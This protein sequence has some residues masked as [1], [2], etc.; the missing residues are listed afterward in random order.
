MYALKQVP[1]EYASTDVNGIFSELHSG[2]LFVLHSDKAFGV[3]LDSVRGVW[4]L[5]A[6]DNP[7][8]IGRALRLNARGEWE[9]DAYLR[10]PGSGGISSGAGATGA[11]QGGLP[12]T[13]SMSNVA[14]ERAASAG[15]V[16]DT[17]RRASMTDHTTGAEVASAAPYEAL[18]S[19]EKRFIDTWAAT[20]STD[21]FAE[22]MQ[23]PRA[24]I[25][26]YLQSDEHR[27]T[28][29]ASSS[30]DPPVLSGPGGAGASRYRRFVRAGSRMDTQKRDRIVRML[31]SNLTM[32][33][34][35]IARVCSS[36]VKTVS[37]LAKACGLERH[38][39]TWHPTVRSAVF[40]DF[41]LFPETSTFDL[42]REHNV[43][44]A[45]VCDFR[46]EFARIQR[47]WESVRRA[48][49]AESRR[50]ELQASLDNDARSLAA[51]RP[52]SPQPGTSSAS[53]PLTEAQKSEI[54]RW[55]GEGMLPDSLSIYL[56][57][58]ET[59]VDAYMRTSEY[60]DYV[61]GLPP[62]AASAAE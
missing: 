62:R 30:G 21:N 25:D 9:L 10:A 58:P 41:I 20:L 57:V 6:Q 4:R 61:R 19:R 32:T 55:G 35:A 38:V 1:D 52:P 16:T 29:Q 60:R 15:S 5:V 37:E 42:A 43:S 48:D 31:E 7:S 39:H 11:R 22:L 18:T 12:I 27:S 14:P 28:V 54:R 47:E 13:S 3:A 17:A 33:Y 51:Q 8:L 49:I 34:S 53:L 26:A 24:K 50:R 36:T 40:D 23:G 59:V 44:P 45:M 56:N 46:I 2:Q